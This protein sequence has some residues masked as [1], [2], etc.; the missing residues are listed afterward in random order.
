MNIKYQ[1]KKLSKSPTGII[2][3]A[4]FVFV[5]LRFLRLTTR[6]KIVNEE[7]LYKTTGSAILCFWHGRLLMMPSI[8]PRGRE[9]NVLISQHSDGKLIAAVQ[10]N[11]GFNVVV[12]ST[13][14]G[15]VS[16]LREFLRIRQREE[17]IVI[18]P[19][20]PRGPAKKV[21]GAIIEIAK[22]LDIPIIPVTFSCNKY[23]KIN[24]WDSLMIPKP[25]GRG[26]FIVGET[27]I[28]KNAEELET[29]LN[30]ITDEAD[31]AFKTI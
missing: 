16:A 22:K 26:V 29:E 4:F 25:F 6:C 11:F 14:N 9:I 30:K 19:D 17:I 2:I 5:Y 27:K 23:K 31:S 13:S 21:G 10:R 1:L 15:G 18:T 8:S 12:G 20:G 28:Y 24:S 3:I 7:N